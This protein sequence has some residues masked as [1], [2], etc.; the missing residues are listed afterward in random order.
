MKHLTTIALL[1]TAVL[2]CT[3]QAPEADSADDYD[4]FEDE[5]T[6]A[7]RA[8]VPEGAPAACVDENDEPIE[9]ELDSECCEG[10][11]CGYDPEGSTRIKTCI[12][13]GG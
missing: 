9:C 11:E 12:W 6:G 7:P 10:F 3:S 13:A 8:S 4:A 1:L 5:D 2:A